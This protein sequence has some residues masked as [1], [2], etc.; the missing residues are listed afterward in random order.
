MSLAA[1]KCSL[2]SFYSVC[3]HY[4]QLYNTMFKLGL[5]QMTVTKDKEENVSHACQ[6]IKDA[7]KDGA[8][9]VVLPVG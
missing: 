3:F 9:M 1:T 5:I 6:L 4:R 7:A 8:D 2:H